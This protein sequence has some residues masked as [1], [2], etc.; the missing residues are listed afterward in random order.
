MLLLL[1]FN[2]SFFSISPIVCVINLLASSVSLI[3]ASIFVIESEILMSV[4]SFISVVSSSF[5]FF[6]EYFVCL[7]EDTSA[8]RGSETSDLFS[9]PFVSTV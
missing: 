8:A 6:G 2:S 3:S 5:T 9:L 4:F 1:K 7:F